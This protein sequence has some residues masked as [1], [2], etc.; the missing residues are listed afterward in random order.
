MDESKIDPINYRPIRLL[1]TVIKLFQ[2]TIFTQIEEAFEILKD[3]NP[4]Q[5][6]FK[7]SHSTNYQCNTDKIE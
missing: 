7:K 6:V 3:P 1:N 4:F 2:K 5:R